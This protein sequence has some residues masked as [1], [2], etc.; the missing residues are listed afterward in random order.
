MDAATASSLKAREGKVERFESRFIRNNMKEAIVQDREFNERG[1]IAAVE[2]KTAGVRWA[3]S[4]P[5]ELS[6]S[7][8]GGEV[9]ELKVTKRSSK[10][11]GANVEFSE[12]RREVSVHPNDAACFPLRY[13]YLP[14]LRRKM[15]G[16]RLPE[17][18]FVPS[19]IKVTWVTNT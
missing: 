16:D 7:Y 6:V 8:P 15:V 5:N 10:L 3:M 1:S 11:D 9:R 19:I 18:S 12:F 14:C 17:I 2:G 13:L 4:N